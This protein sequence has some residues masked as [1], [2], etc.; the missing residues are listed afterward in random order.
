MISVVLVY[1][2]QARAV[3]EKRIDVP[4]GTTLAQ[5]LQKSQVIT[6]WQL[7]DTDT[8]EV[9]IWGRKVPLSHILRDNDRIEIYRPLHVDPKVARR[10]RFARQGARSSGLFA[11][12]RAG[13]KS[14]Y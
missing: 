14:G 1:S 3:Q 8:C 4:A 10:E 7:S 11:K 5:A 6:Q 9:G 12:R 13:A 2:A